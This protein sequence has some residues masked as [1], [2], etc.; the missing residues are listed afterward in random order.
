MSLSAKDIHYSLSC[1][2]SPGIRVFA[3]KLADDYEYFIHSKKQL[4]SGVKI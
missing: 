3:L 4:K 1:V 2:G